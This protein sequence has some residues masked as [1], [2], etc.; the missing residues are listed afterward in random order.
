MS[1]RWLQVVRPAFS[2]Q[3]IKS[4]NLNPIA[5]TT[6]KHIGQ[7]LLDKR[8]LRLNGKY[9]ISQSCLWSKVR[10]YTGQDP[11]TSFLIHQA[12]GAIYRVNNNAPH[13]GIFIRMTR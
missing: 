3:S 2:G 12:A 8:N 11:R 13:G 7:V 5:S 1:P 9:N 10:R 6:P 4:F